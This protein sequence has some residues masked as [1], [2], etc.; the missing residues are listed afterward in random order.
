MHGPLMLL[1]K[2]NE[3][4]DEDDEEEEDDE[5]DND[6]DEDDNEN[7]DEDDDDGEDNDDD[8]VVHFSQFR[9][10]LRKL[11]H[12]RLVDDDE[13]LSSVPGPPEGTLLVPYYPLQSHLHNSNTSALLNYNL[14]KF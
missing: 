6:D 11:I 5:N 7:D 13:H 12:L 3:V 8:D 1:A 4:D 14:G 2:E 10:I 9:F